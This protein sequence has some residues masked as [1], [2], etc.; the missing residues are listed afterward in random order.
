MEN[1]FNAMDYWTSIHRTTTQVLDNAKTN[2]C[3]GAC[4][5][6]QRGLRLQ[7][8]GPEVGHLMIMLIIWWDF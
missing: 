3:A 1:Y 4:G 8:A 5:P 6:V 7:P 2:C